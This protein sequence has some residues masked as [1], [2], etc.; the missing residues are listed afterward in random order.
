M[1]CSIDGCDRP[2]N[3]QHGWCSM[4]YKR[5][6]R[7][8][9]PNKLVRVRNTTCT[10]GGPEWIGAHRHSYQSLVGSIPDGLHLDHLCRV[11]ACVNPEHLE[12]VTLAENN[13]RAAAVKKE[14]A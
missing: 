8:G 3:A 9:D 5:W 7:H 14:V 11:P 1:S 6:K 10:A 13:R 4:H 12:P 2:S